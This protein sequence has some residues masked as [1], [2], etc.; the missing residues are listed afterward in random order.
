MKE[1][2]GQDQKPESKFRRLLN[3]VTVPFKYLKKCPTKSEII[4]QLAISLDEA[5]AKHDLSLIALDKTTKKMEDLNLGESTIRV[6][7]S[8]IHATVTKAEIERDTYW[9]TGLFSTGVA[10]KKILKIWQ[11]KEDIRREYRDSRANLNTEEE[12]ED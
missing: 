11:Q 12:S 3:N 1:Q 7:E 5:R 6:I 2:N 4:D 9:L 10:G 8:H